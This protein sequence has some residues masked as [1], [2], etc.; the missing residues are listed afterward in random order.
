MP[1]S[2]LGNMNFVNQNMNYPATQVS[3]EL[4]KEGFAAIANMAE[5]NEKEKALS[6]LEK[7]NQ[8]QELQKE[9]KEKTEQEEKRKEHKQEAQSN[10]NETLE[11][12]IEET[13]DLPNFHHLDISI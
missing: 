12:N 7:V 9:I 5:F 2:P 3:N 8:T 4:G 6:K 13:N 10:E 11:E 1:V